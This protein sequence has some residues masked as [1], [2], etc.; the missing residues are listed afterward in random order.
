MKFAGELSR[1]LL[2]PLPHLTDTDSVVL[3]CWMGYSFYIKTAL[4]D[5]FG[6]MLY[7][8]IFVL[9]RLIVCECCWKI[10]DCQHKSV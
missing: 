3:S 9:S 4:G 8:P 10:G 6:Q 7:V 2:P 5:I 1:L